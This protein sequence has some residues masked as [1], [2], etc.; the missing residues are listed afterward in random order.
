MY[1]KLIMLVLV[2]ILSSTTCDDSMDPGG[3]DPGSFMFNSRSN[4]L[5]SVELIEQYD[6]TGIMVQF[7]N[8]SDE[9]ISI[10][11]P[12]IPG[13][14]LGKDLFNVTTDS[15]QSLYIGKLAMYKE[16][17]SMSW[18]VFMPGSTEQF[19]VDL[20][21]GY[22]FPIIGYYNVKYSSYITIRRETGENE[23][24]YISSPS[25]ALEVHTPVFYREDSS[26][27]CNSSQTNKINQGVN[28]AKPKTQNAINY[29]AAKKADSYYVKWFGQYDA[30]RF[31]KVQTGYSKIKDALN[32]NITQLCPSSCSGYTA[33]VYKNRPYEIN[34]CW[35][36]ISNMSTAY[37]GE[38]AIHEAS[39][40]NI[41]MGTD[42]H[43][44][45]QSGSMNL[46]KTNPNNAVSNADNVCFY[47]YD[48]PNA[49]TDPVDPDPISGDSLLVNKSMNLNDQILSA[50]KKYKFKLRSNGQ[51]VLNEI[52]VKTLWRSGTANKGGTI[53]WMQGDGN[54]VLYN[55]N[56]KPLWASNTVGKPVVKLQV[57][58]TG[59]AVLK[60]KSGNI[61][62]SVPGN[63][64]DPPDPVEQVAIFGD[65]NFQGYRVDLEAGRH[66]DLEDLKSM[67]SPN[68]SISSIKVA[69]GFKA[70]VYQHHHFGGTYY[71]IINDV[72]DLRT[73]NF[74][75]EISSII[76][77]HKDDDPD[78][79]ETENWTFVVA[80]D[81]RTNDSAHRS[82]LKAIKNNSS[83]YEIYINSGDVV[84]D[85]TNSGQWNTFTNAQN[86]VFG[87][88]WKNKYLSCPGNHDKVQ[89]S[90]GLTNWRKYLPK[91]ANYGNKGKY[92]KYVHKNVTFY[93][94]NADGDKDAQANFIKNNKPNTTWTFA[95]WHYANSYNQ[96]ISALN[97]VKF[98]GI[99]HGHQHIYERREKG[100]YF[101][102]IVGT[103]GAPLGSNNVYGYLECSV[104]GNKMTVRYIKASSG[105]VLDSKTYTANNK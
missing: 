99:F 32:K 70:I 56:H 78:P 7:T 75:D 67:G 49:P 63:T 1:K 29:L 55:A 19:S 31:N 100:S 73:M 35:N 36:V 79:P 15:I 101:Q 64:P 58:D 4:E 103:G 59:K 61:I 41:T 68:D 57:L 37:I 11:N 98:D 46:A 83:N 95:V 42:D 82:V 50:N 34:W 30:S 51:I 20:S 105:Q 26:P 40:W 104:K 3:I 48:I 25:I 87:S 86:S 81:T 62:W 18:T 65:I 96:W 23:A 94:L 2:L 74:N 90:S 6:D 16:S 39:H 88:A 72:N 71:E 76:V 17:G 13:P 27:P 47:P 14:F 21:R 12:D 24:H 60:G 77:R 45:G 66:Y 92:F 84:A 89:S 97:G 10:F 33:Y 91:Q 54:L 85:G 53:L 44:Y 102:T 93:I 52:G 9:V 5:I 28:H 38:T 43:V 80:G 69:S 22:D 8:N